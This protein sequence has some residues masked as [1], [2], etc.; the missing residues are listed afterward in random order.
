MFTFEGHESRR[1]AVLVKQRLLG[2]IV[3][4]KTEASL[5]DVDNKLEKR[6]RRDRER[7]LREGGE[8]TSELQGPGQGEQGDHRHCHRLPVEFKGLEKTVN[9]FY[10]V[11]MSCKTANSQ[12]RR[13]LVREAAA[14]ST[15]KRG[16]LGY[17][18][19]H[20]AVKFSLRNDTNLKR[21]ENLAS[22]LTRI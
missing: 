21:Y 7:H 2:G 17:A 6:W 10:I 12:V 1:K 18:L 8:E 11:L 16:L 4:G 3:F 22:N 15:I 9:M 19:L 14:V 5:A 20:P 13:S